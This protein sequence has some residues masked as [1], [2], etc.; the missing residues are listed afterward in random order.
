LFFKFYKIIMNTSHMLQGRCTIN[1]MK[2]FCFVDNCFDIRAFEKSNFSNNSSKRLLLISEIV[3][4]HMSDCFKT[5]REGNKIF[6]TLFFISEPL[7]NFLIFTIFIIQPYLN[8]L[9]WC[10]IS[11]LFRNILNLELIINKYDLLILIFSENAL[12]TMLKN[13]YL[14]I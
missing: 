13:E 11:S 3:M 14:G 12:E 6:V 8:I 9:D 7:Q 5:I 10:F 2:F 1:V 4:G